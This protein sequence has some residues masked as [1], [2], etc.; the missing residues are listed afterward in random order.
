[1][2]ATP[3]KMAAHATSES[4]PG[5]SNQSEAAIYLGG[6]FLGEKYVCS[7]RGKMW[8]YTPNTEALIHLQSIVENVKEAVLAAYDHISGLE[9]EASTRP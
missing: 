5:L 6:S 2:A 3:E 9:S 7:V 8:S 1:M 4:A